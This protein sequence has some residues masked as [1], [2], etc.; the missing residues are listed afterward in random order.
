MGRERQLKPIFVNNLIYDS[1]YGLKQPKQD[2]A[3]ME[4]SR[5]TPNYYFASTDKGVEQMAK[6]ASLGIWYDTGYQE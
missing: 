1:R 2:G 3:D 6:D 5:L 4:H